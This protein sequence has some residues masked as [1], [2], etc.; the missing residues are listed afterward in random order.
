[1][2]RFLTGV[3]DYTNEECRMD[4]LH[5]DMTLYSIIVYA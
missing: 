1:M 3:F 2:S 5:G 4:M